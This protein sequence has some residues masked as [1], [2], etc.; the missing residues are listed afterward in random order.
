MFPP[1]LNHPW[2]KR[3]KKKSNIETH[4]P[5]P[6]REVPNIPAAIPLENFPTEMPL[7]RGRVTLAQI[8]GTPAR[9][10]G[11]TPPRAATTTTPHPTP[12]VV[13]TTTAPAHEARAGRKC[14][15]GLSFEQLITIP[16]FENSPPNLGDSQVDA[17]GA[18]ASIKAFMVDEEALPTTNRVRP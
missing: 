17:M 18:P 7:Q 9:P 1:R 3:K 13:T 14:L 6:S 4:S 15:R 16:D 5:S 2:R 10:Q 11:Q 8:L 12:P